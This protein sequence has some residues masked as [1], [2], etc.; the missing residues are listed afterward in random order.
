MTGVVIVGEVRVFPVSVSV[1]AIVAKLL[2]DNAVLNC[3]VVPVTVLDAR[4]TVLLVK[5]EVDAEV[6][7]ASTPVLK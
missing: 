1:P 7:A 6:T 3:A 5:V 2:S 4:L